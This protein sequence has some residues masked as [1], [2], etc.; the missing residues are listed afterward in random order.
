M[1]TIP[2]YIKAT[3]PQQLSDYSSPV[4]STHFYQ[5]C[6][7]E[8]IPQWLDVTKPPYIVIFKFLQNANLL[9]NFSAWF[10]IPFEWPQLL[11]LKHCLLFHCRP[12]YFG[13]GDLFKYL[14]Y[15]PFILVNAAYCGNLSVGIISP[16]LKVHICSL[17][18]SSS[19]KHHISFC[20]Q[21]IRFLFGLGP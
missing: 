21:I 18:M 9:E 14:T 1:Y 12:T 11:H 7:N 2:L 17:Q 3:F 13:R 20:S 19:R 5:F 8:F 15:K 4:F 6:E 10:A 16:A